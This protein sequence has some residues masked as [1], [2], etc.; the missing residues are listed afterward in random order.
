METDKFRAEIHAE[1]LEVV[2]SVPPLQE[3]LTRGEQ[4]RLIKSTAAAYMDRCGSSVSTGESCIIMTAGPPGSGKSSTVAKHV[5][6]FENRLVIDPDV[7]RVQPA[8]WCLERGVYAEVLE[9][10]LTDGLPVMILELSAALQTMSTEVANEVR[11][12]AF[13]E[14]LAVV[15]EGTMSSRLYVDRLLDSIAKTEYTHAVVLSV[16]SGLQASQALA[17]KRWW[18]GRQSGGLGGRLVD[19]TV[20]DRLYPDGTRESVCR[21]QAQYAAKQVADGRTSLSSLN[22][23]LYDDGVLSDE[24]EVSRV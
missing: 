1:A 8:R 18:L 22:L 3:L 20:I 17:V 5:A 14:G 11:R 4:R 16:E 2:R 19:P 15:V 12:R 6:D 7:A 23:R 10:V 13:S 9:T 24:V 21:R